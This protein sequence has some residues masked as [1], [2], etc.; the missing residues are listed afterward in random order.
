MSNKL[1]FP[2]DFSQNCTKHLST[3]ALPWQKCMSHGTILI[4]KCKLIIIWECHNV[5]ALF[6]TK[7]RGG[8]HIR[9]K[10]RGGQQCTFQ[11][12]HLCLRKFI[13]IATRICQFSQYSR[14]KLDMLFEIA[15][16]VEIVIILGKTAILP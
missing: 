12:S 6:I 4:S 1:Q 14:T 7:T 13:K 9:G 16:S 10:T 5:S 15:K 11:W 2:T 8:Q 3:I